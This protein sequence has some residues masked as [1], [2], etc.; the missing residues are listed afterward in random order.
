MQ[1][2]GF[3][4]RRLADGTIDYGFYRAEA[5][6]LRAEARHGF[7]SRCGHWFVT[8]LNTLTARSR[9]LPSGFVESR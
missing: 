5:A 8:R 6:R 4:V 7:W 1:D 9:A 2:A 3:L